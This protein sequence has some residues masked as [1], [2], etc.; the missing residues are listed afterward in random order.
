MVIGL[1]VS[2]SQLTMSA[3]DTRPVQPAGLL[4]AAGA[5]RRMGQP[6]ALV[7]GS[8]GVPWLERGSRPLLDAGCDPVFVVLGAEAESARLLLSDDARLVAVFADDWEQGM[9]ASLAAGMRAVSST[10][11]DAVII[12]LVDLPDLSLDSVLR[13]AGGHSPASLRQATYDGRPGH[14][15][16]VGRTHWPDFTAQLRGDSGGR[17]YLVDRG[18]EEVDCSDLGSGQDR[19]ALSDPT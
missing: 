18:V 16:L 13:V 14:P 8:D 17:D 6:K 2:M 5:G 1:T 15:V 9:G 7:R 12:T 4:L 3:E 10:G 19:D 11:N